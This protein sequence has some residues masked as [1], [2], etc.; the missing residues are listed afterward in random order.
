MANVFPVCGPYNFLTGKL[1][2]KDK[3]AI[4]LEVPVSGSNYGAVNI[5]ALDVF[6]V[7]TAPEPIS[8]IRMVTTKGIVMNPGEAFP[9]EESIKDTTQGLEIHTYL[10]K[11]DSSD[12]LYWAGDNWQADDGWKIR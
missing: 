6:P 9:N 1:F 5:F 11:E 3:D 8:V 12:I 10:N 2:S 7:G 4:V